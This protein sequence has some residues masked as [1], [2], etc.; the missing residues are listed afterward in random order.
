MSSD[1][2]DPAPRCGSREPPD[3]IATPGHRRHADMGGKVVHV[4]VEGFRTSA[5]FSDCKPSCPPM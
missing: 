5:L 4:P 3:M 1:D 2:V